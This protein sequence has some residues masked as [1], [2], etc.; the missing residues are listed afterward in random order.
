MVPN[1]EQKKKVLNI[2]LKT[3]S[4]YKQAHPL[5]SQL[6]LRKERW[7]GRETLHLG[8]TKDCVTMVFLALSM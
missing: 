7:G 1:P 6:L 4:K 5:T 2:L 8:F 3:Y